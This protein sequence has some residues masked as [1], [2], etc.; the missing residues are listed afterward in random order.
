MRLTAKGSFGVGLRLNH[1]DTER[2]RKLRSQCFGG[3][4]GWHGFLRRHGPGLK[5]SLSVLLIGVITSGCA[6]QIL[7]EGW[8]IETS[9]I[10][11]RQS[12]AYSGPVATKMDNG[13]LVFEY[14]ARRARLGMLGSWGSSTE[15]GRHRITNVVSFASLR[16]VTS[17]SQLRKMAFEWPVADSNTDLMKVRELPFLHFERGNKGRFRLPQRECVLRYKTWIWYVPPS[18]E[19]DLPL[20]CVI[21]ERRLETPWYAYPARIALFPI[22]LV[23][24]IFVGMF[25]VFRTD[26]L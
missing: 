20:A 23:G 22:V 12:A 24:D 9:P 25:W 2:T 13:D 7:R 15:L 26:D 8:A 3:V 17:L 4:F 19:G 16:P 18:K 10:G 5:L 14:E 1:D 11:E 6:T 21:S